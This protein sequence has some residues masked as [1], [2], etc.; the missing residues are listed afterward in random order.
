M[1]KTLFILS[2]TLLGT[3]LGS[4]VLGQ[5]NVTTNALSLGMPEL[6]L[7]SASATQINLQLT[8]AVAGEAVKA[9][10]SDSTARLKISSVITSAART[11]SASVSAVPAGTVLK[12]QAQ[13]PNSSFGGTPGTFVT[14][15]A[16]PTSSSTDIITGI[17][18]CYSGTATDDGYKLK[19]TWGLLNAATSYAAVRA[20][21]AGVV[22]T[23]TLTLTASN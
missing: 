10:V 2:I 13:T 3:L 21:G 9:S 14:D 8:T 15:A 1:K 5:V 4:N 22:V 7:L 16:L 17:G 19:Y 23:V 20:T 6:S 12:L 18:S 11:L